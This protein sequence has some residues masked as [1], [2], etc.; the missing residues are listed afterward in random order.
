[1]NQSSDQVLNSWIQGEELAEAMVPMIGSLYRE[2][3]IVVSIYG[4]PLVRQSSTNIVKAHRY[5][6]QVIDR[7]LPIAESYAVLSAIA[8]R[9]LDSAR[10]DLGKLTTGFAQDGNGRSIDEYLDEV[11][12]PISSGSGRL[13]SEPTDVVLYGFGRIGR[14]LARILIE[15]TGSGEKLRLR[16]IVLRPGDAGDAEKRAS[17]LRRDSVH[18]PFTGTIKADSEKSQIIANGNA[19]QLIY[20]KSPSEVDY[21]AYGIDNAIVVDNTGIWRDEEGLGQHLAAKG[22]K[23]VLLTAP[24]KGAIKNIIYGV[25]DGEITES[26]R[27]LS[28]ASCTTNA[29]VP[30]LKAMHDEYEV[31]SG[32]LETVHAYTNDQN[33]TDN[34]HNKARR[35]RSAP[36]NLVITETGAATAVAKA[37]PE[38]A[39][40]LTGN[41]IRVPTPN[42]SLAILNLELGT[43]ADRDTINDYLRRLSVDSTLRDQLDY[44]SSEEIVSSDLVGSD[45]A[46][47]VDSKA[48]IVNGSRCVLYV[49]YDN[50]AG[51]SYQVVRI[52]Q[53]LAGL[54]YPSVP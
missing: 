41:A 52:V 7:E 44:T 21:T 51:Y 20:A 23:R 37:L 43:A 34:Y 8:T 9:P 16:G 38:L 30:V 1:M 4:R 22:V 17:L 5:A 53:E 24:G 27:A 32:H 14:L 40:R 26:D 35:G 42:V 47:I 36:L 2:R 33:L 50:E 19:I 18:G 25:N 46:G 29:I 15:R 28:A 13:L 49:W 12:A 6:R 31:I 45:R 3:D 54:T 10:V 48:T 39:G 11:L